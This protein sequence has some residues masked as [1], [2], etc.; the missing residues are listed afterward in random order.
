MGSLWLT[1]HSLWL[2]F[3]SLWAHLLERFGS[4]LVPLGSL[5]LTLALD[6]LAFGVS[7]HNFKYFS[8]F[9][10][11]LD[12]NVHSPLFRLMSTGRQGRRQRP[13]GLFNKSLY[14]A[15]SRSQSTQIQQLQ[16]TPSYKNGRRRYSPAIA[17]NCEAS[18]VNS[19][20]TTE[21]K[22]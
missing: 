2:T 17:E 12:F 7:W 22:E 15:K 9:I 6:L 19:F 1:F 10:R 4:L 18:H 5:L 3:G 8:I 21:N 13:H 14:H 16:Q 11:W 20:L